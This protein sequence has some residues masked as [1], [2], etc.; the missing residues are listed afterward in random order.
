M[1]AFKVTHLSFSL[2]L[3]GKGEDG[4][5]GGG[6]GGSHQQY[7]QWLHDVQ[8]TTSSTKLMTCRCGTADRKGEGGEVSGVWQRLPSGSSCLLDQMACSQ[9]VRRK[10]RHVHIRNADRNHAY[11]NL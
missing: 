2:L 9:P 10:A 1:H 3:W 7:V 5:G 4:K 11:I 6:E 8:R